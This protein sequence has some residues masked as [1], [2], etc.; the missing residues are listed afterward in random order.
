MPNLLRNELGNGIANAFISFFGLCIFSL[1]VTV[2]LMFPLQPP[3]FLERPC[4]VTHRLLIVPL[5]YLV[6]R[7]VCDLLLHCTRILLYKRVLAN[8]LHEHDHHS[9][10]FSLE[11]GL[12]EG[13][14]VAL[15]LAVI[16]NTSLKHG[17]FPFEAEE[18]VIQTLLVIIL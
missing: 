17:Y 7:G 4:E 1:S 12:Q 14:M 9:Q 8:H 16:A 18:G 13:Y 5:D 6:L 11:I 15:D 3:P 10:M 2:P